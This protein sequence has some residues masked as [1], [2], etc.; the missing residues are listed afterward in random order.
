MICVG[1]ELLAADEGL[2]RR[3]GC[4]VGAAEDEHVGR[5]DAERDAVF[6]EGEDNAAAKLA[7]DGVALVGADTKLDGIGDSAAFDLVDAEDVGVSDGDFFVGGVV[8]E[9]ACYLT[10][11]GDDFVGVGAGVDAD[12]EGRYGVVAGEIGDGG[13]LTV[14]DNVEGAVGVTEGGSAEREVFYSAFESGDVDDLAD[15]VL[16]LD[17][18]EDAVE[19]VFEDALRT[20]ADADAED[21]G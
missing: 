17:E 14:R 20:E 9:V 12:V 5:I 11:D 6:F 4:G 1:I 15:V 16:V 7:E 10:E 2:L 21:A 8:A 3:R 18:D 19:D 13:D